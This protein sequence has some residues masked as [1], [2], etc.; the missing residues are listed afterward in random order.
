MDEKYGC[1]Q[2][3][4]LIVIA[5]KTPKYSTTQLGWMMKHPPLEDL[6]INFNL[7]FYLHM[8]ENNKNKNNTTL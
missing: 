4:P 1:V 7:R 8:E 2:Y 5:L 6:F 3:F